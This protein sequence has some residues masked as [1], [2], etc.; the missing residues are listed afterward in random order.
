MPFGIET[1]LLVYYYL[2]IIQAQLEENFVHWSDPLINDSNSFKQK[3]L[4]D[5]KGWLLY[6]QNGILKFKIRNQFMNWLIFLSA[7]KF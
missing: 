4:I 7:P 5:F 3:F 2:Y 1:L 6:W